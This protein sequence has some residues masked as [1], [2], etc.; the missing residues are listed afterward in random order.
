ME[1]A[2]TG[3]QRRS[4][5]NDNLDVCHLLA[6]RSVFRVALPET[7]NFGGLGV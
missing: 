2:Y 7:W 5:A 6:L 3:D 4:C 1:K